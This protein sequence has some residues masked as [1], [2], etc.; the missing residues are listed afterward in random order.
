[1]F[2]AYKLNKQSD[3]INPLHTLFPIW[4]QS[5]APYSV[6]TIASWPSYRFLKKQVRWSGIPISLRIFQRY[7]YYCGQESLRRYGV[8][9]IIN[10]TVCS[11]VL[12]CNFHNDRII[13]V[14]FQGKPFNITII[15]V[16][17][18]ACNAEEAEFELFY[19]GLQDVLELAPK[20]DVL[21]IIGDRNA[22]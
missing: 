11:A 20:K 16:Y 9:I 7:I 18:L 19:E 21:F 6:L 22:K 17:A 4:N 1:M 5:I 8:A 13:S 3:N 12:E 14:H 10:K 2:S 15:Q